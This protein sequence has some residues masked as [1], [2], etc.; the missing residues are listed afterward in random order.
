M[1]ELK[2]NWYRYLTGISLGIVCFLFMT[3]LSPNLLKDKIVERTC[4]GECLG[5]LKMPTDS[6]HK[7]ISILDNATNNTSSI[8]EK[9]NSLNTRLNDFYIF[10]GILITLLL[11]INISV[12]IKAASEVENHM[13]DNFETYKD[14]LEGLVGEAEDSLAKIK[15]I[16]STAQGSTRTGTENKAITPNDDGH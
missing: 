9:F 12:Y 15:G 16:L 13:K 8:D 2:K 4:K 3:C 10:S 11:A 14:K 1:Q 5:Y 7:L 6:L